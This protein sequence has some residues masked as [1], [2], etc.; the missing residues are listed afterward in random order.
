MRPKIFNKTD[1]AK[2]VPVKLLSTHHYSW[3][4]QAQMQDSDQLALFSHL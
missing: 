4:L 1:E 2:K 3:N